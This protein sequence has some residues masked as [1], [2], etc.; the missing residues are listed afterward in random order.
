MG[1]YLL[2]HSEPTRRRAAVAENVRHG[3]VLHNVARDQRAVRL[4]KCEL[5]AFRVGSAETRAGGP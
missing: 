3:L 1:G 5:V 2:Q 4:D